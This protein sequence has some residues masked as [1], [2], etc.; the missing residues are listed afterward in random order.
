ML[1][2]IPQIN[3]KHAGIKSISIGQVAIG[4]ISVGSLVLNNADLSM[5]AA[6]AVLQNMS[7]TVTLHL[8]VSWHVHI[9]LPDGIPDIDVGDTYDLGSFSFSMPVG[10][11]VI[12]GLSN[13]NFHIP[14]LT[15]QNL[16]VSVNPI[17]L[18]LSNVI[19]EQIHAADLVLPSQGFTLAGLTLTS[20]AGNGIGIPAAKINQATVS[21]VHGD[22]VK[23]PSFALN[24]LNMPAAQIPVITSSTPL[25][26][27]ANLQ[28][29]SIGF[30]A[31]ILTLTINI[32]PS[33]LSHIDHLE[34]TGASANATVGQTVL[35]DVTLPYNVLNL[36]L[37]QIGLDTVDIPSFSVS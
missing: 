34:I 5:S 3:V 21:Q 19:A 9:G 11:V 35:H 4:P 2:K 20:L 22:S 36:T 12:P 14:S 28:G 10:N 1:A 23:V 30:D 26:I 16:S 17:G 33:V 6:Q 18:Q 25:N 8:T 27:P 7:V 24:G 29:Q 37:S 31:S 13:L 15:A 32:T